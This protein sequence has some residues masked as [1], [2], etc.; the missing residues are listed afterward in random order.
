MLTMLEPMALSLVSDA[1]RNS[2]SLNNAL[3]IFL[4]V[5][6]MSGIALLAVRVAAMIVSGWVISLKNQIA[7]SETS[8]LR[9]IE[10]QGGMPSVT[11]FSSINQPRLDQMVQAI[12]RSNSSNT[13]QSMQS[14]NTR[15]M[16]ISSQ[17]LQRTSNA[18]SSTR[19]SALSRANKTAQPLSLLRPV[20][21]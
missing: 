6:V 12:E 19:V 13:V 8:S 3:A 16:S 9:S 10:V 21:S 1:A 5:L 7:G 20:R 4:A 17:Q 14:N 2:Y 18:S 11:A 15:I